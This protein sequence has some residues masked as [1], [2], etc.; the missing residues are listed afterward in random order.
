MGQRR[1]DPREWL[2]ADLAKTT[3]L[4][5]AARSIRTAPRLL[6]WL[7]AYLVLAYGALVAILALTGELSA[8]PQWAVYPGLVAGG[9]FSAR[10]H[11]TT[12]K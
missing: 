10:L 12:T 1:A 7:L 6:L 11:R 9:L 2:R 5:G 4:R 8:F 3:G